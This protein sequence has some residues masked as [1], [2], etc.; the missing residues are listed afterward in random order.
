MTPRDAIAPDQ[1]IPRRETMPSA[2]VVGQFGN[3][4]IHIFR[5]NN[6]SGLQTIAIQDLE[7]VN[8]S[9][10]DVLPSSCDL[11]WLYGKSANIA[12]IPGWNGF[13]EEATEGKPFK[14]S[15]ILCLPFINA[16]PN[17]HDTIFTALLSAAKKCRTLKQKTCFVTFDQPLYIKAR[18]IV[19]LSLIHI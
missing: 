1:A 3:V 17:N 9:N 11:L 18:Y 2:K 16:P 14:R 15:Q 8:P 4:P 10:K 6:E 7:A 19:T 12:S 13:M 5:K